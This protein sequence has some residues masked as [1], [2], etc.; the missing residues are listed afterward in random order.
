MRRRLAHKILSQVVV[1]AFQGDVLLEQI[2]V[3]SGNLR[4]IFIHRVTPGSAADKMALRPGT[5]I[6]MVSVVPAPGSSRGGVAVGEGNPGSRGSSWVSSR[7]C[8]CSEQR[9]H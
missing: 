4:S 7:H 2:S 8:S 3:I 5:Q 6:V 1:L 9:A